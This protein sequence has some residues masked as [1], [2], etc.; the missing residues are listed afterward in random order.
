V[1]APVYEAFGSVW[2]FGGAAV[3]MAALVVAARVLDGHGSVRGVPHPF[4]PGLPVPS[5]V[6]TE[7]DT[8]VGPVPL[9]PG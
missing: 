1:A 4:T 3:L 2:L 5:A 7:V 6:R 8:P 9:E